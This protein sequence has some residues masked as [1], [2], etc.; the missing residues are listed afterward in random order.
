MASKIWTSFAA[1]GSAFGRP[2]SKR[3]FTPY[4]PTVPTGSYDP[5]LDSALYASQRGLGDVQA[6]SA[7][8]AQRGL[9]DYGLGR[10]Q[11]IQGRDRQ[12]ADLTTGHDRGLADFGTSRTRSTEDYSSNVAA[13]QRAFSQL[14]NRQ[15][16]G[17]ISQGVVHGGSLLQ[18]A[19]KR[20]AN[21][22]IERAPIDTGYQR[23][24][25]DI[26]T[27]EGRLNQDFTT[28]TGRVGEDAT[29]QLGQLALQFQRQGDDA[30]TALLRAQREAGQFG[31]DTQSQKLFQA[32]QAGYVAPP[33][34]SN[35]F[36]N[37]AG[38]SYRVIMVGGKKVRV[39][40]YGRRI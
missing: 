39:D 9:V 22:A 38:Q 33:R 25:A 34:P 29:S 7:T 4:D 26:T 12:L 2:V 21:E 30:Q 17:A 3:A 23:Q 8:A 31:I 5:G 32:S 36:T 28:N 16:Q 14:G 40:Q 27:G 18:A 6:D 24:Q 15:R 20:T 1:P 35:E 13:L 10:D 19:A 37:A 11:I